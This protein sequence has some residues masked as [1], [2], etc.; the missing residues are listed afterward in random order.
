MDVIHALKERRS[1]NYFQQ[2]ETIPKETIMQILEVANLAPSSNNL[3]P[4]EVIVVTSA[5]KKKIL[6]K[7]AFDQAKV[8]EAAA[9]FIIVANPSA[10][11][12]NIDEVLDSFEMLG[13]RNAKDREANKQGAL[14]F[15]GEKES[16]RRKIFAVKNASLFAMCLMIAARGYGFETHPM[17][18][19]IEE[20]VKK[21]FNIPQD[22]IIPMLIALGTL[23]K[24]VTLL[25]RA[26]RRPVERFVRFE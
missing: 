16:L 2:D 7:C 12:E 8:E 11:E 3:Q 25:P 20:N 9:V 22:R 23:R 14:N 21:E 13:Y 10:A 24:G 19:F 17:D 15:I 4:W 18:G 5:E 26:W 6:R 1:I